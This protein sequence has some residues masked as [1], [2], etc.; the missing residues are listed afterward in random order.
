MRFVFRQRMATV[1]IV[2]VVMVVVG[3]VTSTYVHAFV[4]SFNR[5]SVDIHVEKSVPNIRF[6]MTA[7]DNLNDITTDDTATS[8]TTLVKTLRSAKVTNVHG[9]VVSL[10][11]VMGIEKSVVVLLRHLG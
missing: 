9:Q 11:D 3:M 1:A 4:P 8:T 6:Q 5:N 10:G 7:F 2:T